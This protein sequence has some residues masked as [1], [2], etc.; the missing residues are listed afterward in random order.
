[1]SPHVRPKSTSFPSVRFLRSL[2][3]GVEYVVEVDQAPNLFVIRKQHRGGGSRGDPAQQP[4]AGARQAASFLSQYYVL[5][6]VIY[7]VDVC[8]FA[9]EMDH[10]VIY[11]NIS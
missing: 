9:F 11:P 1:M 8:C 7:Q 10:C 6:K 3:P 5:D 4:T 2:P